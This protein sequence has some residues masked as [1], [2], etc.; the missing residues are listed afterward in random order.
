MNQGKT[1]YNDPDRGT[2]RFHLPEESK[3]TVQ[4]TA[5]AP[6]GVPVR[7]SA[8]PTREKGVY[9]ID[10]AVKPGESR[11]DITYEL[12]MMG[13][14][15]ISGR[16]LHKGSEVRV[17]TPAG[18]TAE[19]P[20]L[21]LLG[22]EP[23]TKAAIYSLEGPAYQFTVKGSGSLRAAAPAGGDDEDSGPGI[24]QIQPRIYDQLPLI[25]GLSFT[26]L[27]F[28]FVLL[29]RK[30]ESGRADTPAKESEGKRP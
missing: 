19:G 12:P 18:V 22:Q 4:I 17:V 30:G 25:L 5:H 6:D 26:M 10:F 28:G 9:G 23:R 14:A 29:Y 21:E 16:L 1:T 24:Q 11:I 13:S 8:E 15:E 20:G 7:R 2:F 3:G 27:A